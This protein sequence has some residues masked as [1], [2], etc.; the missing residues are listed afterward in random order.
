[1]RRETR[2]LAGLGLRTLD[3]AVGRTDLLRQRRTGDPS[4]DALDLR[5]LLA[6][7]GAGPSRY[8]G[9]VVPD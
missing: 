7:A 5:R 3:E 8:V 6:R 9:D 1:M 2:L 4:A